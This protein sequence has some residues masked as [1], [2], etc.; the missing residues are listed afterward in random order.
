MNQ[1]GSCGRDFASV[2]AFDSHRRG[3]HAYTYSEGVKMEPLRED[4]RR[5]LWP[6]EFAK[7]G[8][9]LDERGR[10]QLAEQA[11]KARAHFRGSA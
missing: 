5:C 2:A 7:V 9:A 11:A 4:G 6:E 8:L 10:W 1:C 3:V